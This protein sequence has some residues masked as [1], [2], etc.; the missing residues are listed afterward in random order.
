MKLVIQRVNSANVL[1]DGNEVGKIA[2]GLL[3]FVGV[4]IDD[5]EKIVEKYFNK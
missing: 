2:K 4:A 3:V 1:I 5:D